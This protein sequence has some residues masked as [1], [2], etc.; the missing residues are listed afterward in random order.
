MFQEALLESSSTALGRKRWPV[1]A[2]FLLETLAAGIVIAVPLLSTGIIPVSGH[3]PIIAPLQSI[4]LATRP[5]SPPPSGSADGAHYASAR[6]VTVPNR[7]NRF[8]AGRAQQERHNPGPILSWDGP[9]SS[10]PNL[11][12]SVEQQK[13]APPKR[14]RIRLS[15]LSEAQLINKAEPVYPRIAQL[16]GLAGS[17]KLHAIIGKD[18]TV[19]S[20]SLISGQPILA[21]AALEAVAQWRYRPY[22]LNGEPVEVETFITVNFR[23]AGR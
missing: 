11:I 20:L 13:P 8:Y 9:G 7:P 17:V 22:L 10:G 6:I 3:V 16:A 4:K 14:E 5:A 12:G 18:G 19:Q 15:M 1:A 23:K 21:A 2:A